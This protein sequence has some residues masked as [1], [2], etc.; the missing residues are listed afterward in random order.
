MDTSAGSRY[1]DFS[2]LVLFPYLFNSDFNSRH[3][4]KGIL[5]QFRLKKNFFLFFDINI[6]KSQKHKS[7]QMKKH[8]FYV[9][10]QV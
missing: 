5:K 8:R 2:E 4:F 7:E 1:H 6:R 9:L 10:S 3:F